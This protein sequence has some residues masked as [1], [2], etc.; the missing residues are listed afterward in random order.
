[1]N[2]YEQQRKN[3]RLSYLIFL[4]YF[5]FFLAIGLGF[6]YFILGKKSFYIGT[7]FAIL[8]SVIILLS[9]L[10]N[11]INR[12]ILATGS[13]KANPSDFKEMQFINVVEEMAIAAGIQKP[14]CY[15]VVFDND[16]NAFT[17]G[18]SPS[19]S[20]IFVTFGLL[21]ELNR[22]EL[23][24][25][26][27]HEMTHIRSGDMRLLTLLTVLMN[28]IAILSDTGRRSLRGTRIS[29][30]NSRNGGGGV[31][32]MIWLL[33]L[34]LSP[35]ISRILAMA[36]SRQREYLADAGAA[37]LT[38]NPRALISALEKIRSA[39]RSTSPIKSIKDSVAYLCIA[40][41]N[42]TLSEERTG[43]FKSLF[44]THPP[45]EKRI[46]ALKLMAYEQEKIKKS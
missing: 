37:E 7:I 17:A 33:F 35:I 27:A 32:F 5:L 34:I 6:D 43:F 25:V 4:I 22:D 9:S 40:D 39:I 26:I 23:Q 11:A 31:V 19:R 36:I 29:G 18:L 3:K 44:A 15:V 41:P 30:R 12:I 38:R 24:A 16:L 45:I 42:G 10:R 2:I 21:N 1:M 20:Y 8:F 14:E 28:A 46:L 13:R